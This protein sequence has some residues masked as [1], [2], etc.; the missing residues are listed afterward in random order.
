[1]QI[2]SSFF[3]FRDHNFKSIS[4]LLSSFSSRVRFHFGSNRFRSILIFESSDPF[5]SES[6]IGIDS[7]KTGFGASLAMLN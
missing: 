2:D 4:V 6:R 1:M 5:G 7:K 3:R